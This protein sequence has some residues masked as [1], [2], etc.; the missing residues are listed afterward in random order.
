MGSLARISDRIFPVEKVTPCLQVLGAVHCSVKRHTFAFPREIPSGYRGRCT[1]S[2]TGTIAIASPTPPWR[3]IL[4]ILARDV[5]PN[6]GQQS[7]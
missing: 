7:E 2:A 5:S 1:V 3:G 4:I 6:A